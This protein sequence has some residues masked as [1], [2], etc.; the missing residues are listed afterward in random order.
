[1]ES[2]QREMAGEMTEMRKEIERLKEKLNQRDRE[3]QVK[4]CIGKQAKDACVYDTAGGGK[5]KG[6]C[7]VNALS[8]SL[9]CQ[10]IA[11]DPE[12]PK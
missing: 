7:I 11:Q 8:R 5:K 9:W 6:V 2:E 3:N 1:M 12:R 10:P 4:A